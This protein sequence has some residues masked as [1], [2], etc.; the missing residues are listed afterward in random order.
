MYGIWILCTFVIVCADASCVSPGSSLDDETA[1][2]SSRPACVF[3]SPVT[4]VC[5]EVTKLL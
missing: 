1:L 4:A 5:H 3:P 2:D